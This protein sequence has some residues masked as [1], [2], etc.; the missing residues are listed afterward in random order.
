MPVT[1]TGNAA[2][3]AARPLSGGGTSALA[4]TAWGRRFPN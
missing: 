1:G 3:F 2:R 4:W